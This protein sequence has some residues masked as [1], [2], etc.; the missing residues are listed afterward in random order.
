M[1]R[2]TELPAVGMDLTPGATQDM[3]DEA[4]GG[5]KGW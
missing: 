3:V 2:L 1:D 5:P 4:R